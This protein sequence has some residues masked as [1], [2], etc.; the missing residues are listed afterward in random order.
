MCQNPTMRPPVLPSAVAIA[1]LLLVLPG[2]TRFQAFL[3]RREG[4]V[5]STGPSSGRTTAEVLRLVEA[6]RAA[7]PELRFLQVSATGSMAPLFGSNAV[8][9][10]EPVDPADV[11]AG[12]IVSVV[13]GG[14]ELVHVV[15][16]AGPVE[17]RTRGF[18]SRRGERVAPA[19]VTGRATTVL[20][21]CGTVPAAGG[22]G[23]G[24]AAEGAGYRGGGLRLIEARMATV[25]P[26]AELSEEADGRLRLRLGRGQAI[27]LAV[28]PAGRSPAAASSVDVAWDPTLAGM[29][30][31]YVVHDAA[32]PELG[33]LIVD[34][35]MGD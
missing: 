16:Q 24:Y 29:V 35:E 8:L 31:R 13:V 9:A 34:V 22:W 11:R 18:A 4:G 1:S 3:G 12:D 10:M 26:A 27:R 2:C 14:R 23:V 21:H 19:Q 30:R 25:G 28:G 15:E 20:Y 32:A 17:L 7:D 5:A 33:T 6:L